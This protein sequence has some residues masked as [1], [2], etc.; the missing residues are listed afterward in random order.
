M[1]TINL[2]AWVFFI[3]FTYPNLN[4]AVSD[5]LHTSHQIKYKYRLASVLIHMPYPIT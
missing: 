4:F 3:P 1:I 5:I 2:N